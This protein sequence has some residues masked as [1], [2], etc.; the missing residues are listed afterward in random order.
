M[1]KRSATETLVGSSSKTSRK[2]SRQQNAIAQPDGMGEFEDAWED[3]IESDEDVVDAKENVDG[4]GDGEQD[5][6]WPFKYH[7]T[8][9]V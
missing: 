1:S 6:L 8:L 5:V 2:E 9:Y 3:E 4:D 7:L